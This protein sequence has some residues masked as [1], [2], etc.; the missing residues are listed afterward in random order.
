MAQNTVVNAQI[1][2]ARNTHHKLGRFATFS[3]RARAAGVGLT[4]EP[5][6]MTAL[7]QQLAAD[8]QQS[9]QNRTGYRKRLWQIWQFFED[10]ASS[11]PVRPTAATHTLRHGRLHT[12]ARVARQAKYLSFV[13]LTT[14]LIS[15][16][17]SILE[18]LP[19]CEYVDY[20]QLCDE[21]VIDGSPWFEI[22]SVCIIIFSIEYVV[23]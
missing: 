8:V 12:A 7:A 18:T 20:V 14:I 21:R 10:P 5:E 17:N 9:Q 16:L 15:I 3:T 6:D 4:D 13:M 2:A 11:R 19:S 1:G 22:E 23:K